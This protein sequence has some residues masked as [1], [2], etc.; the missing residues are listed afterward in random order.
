MLGGKVD[1]LARGPAGVH[2]V[3]HKTAGVDVTPGSTYWSRL[4]LDSQVSLY[5]EGAKALG[6]DVVSCIY[7]VVYKPGLKPLKATPVEAR[8]WTKTGALYASQRAEDETVEQY[9]E[10]L[11]TDIG[12]APD[13]YYQRGEVV[14]L[15]TER[16]D[17]L[18]DAWQWGRVLRE[19][20]LANRWPRNPESCMSYGH[21]CPFWPVCSGTASLDDPYL[22]RRITCH[23]ELSERAA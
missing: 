18:H 17:F 13:R 5:H 12:E 10:R 11:A 20:E 6:Y 23:E 14:R 19:S 7:D 1:A 16:A 8:K 21:E 2:L 15:E 3:E 4:R 22:Y 9:R